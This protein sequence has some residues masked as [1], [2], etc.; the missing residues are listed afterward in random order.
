MGAER[1]ETRAGV[2]YAE[3]QIMG[4]EP[5]TDDYES[6]RCLEQKL[7]RENTRFDHT[8]M[9]R[10]LADDFLEFGRSGRI[11]ERADILSVRA[12]AIQALIP[13]PNFNVRLLSKDVAQVTYDS[14]ETIDGAV[15]T[16]RRSSIWSRA[17]KGWVLR[18]HQGT[19]AHD[20]ASD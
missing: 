18:F 11:Y 2:R 12:H 16:V 6:L 19:T 3:E 10:V 7:W 4:T 9:E 20:N 15:R 8:F 13:L 5:N 14:V 1:S 17:P